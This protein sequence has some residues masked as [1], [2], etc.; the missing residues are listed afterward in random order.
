MTI[1]DT[2]SIHWWQK[3]I[4]TILGIALS[5][6]ILWLTAKLH[7]WIERDPGRTASQLYPHFGLLKVSEP[8]ERSGVGKLIDRVANRVLPGS[9]TNGILDTNGRLRSGHQLAATAVAVLLAIYLLSGVAFSPTS[10]LHPPAAIF[11]LL[12]LLCLLTW[13]FSGLA[14]FFDVLRVPV[15]TFS[16]ALSLVFGSIGTD[17]TFKGNDL[18]DTPASPKRS[19][20]PGNQLGE[21]TLTRRSS[22]LHGRW[23]DT[24]FRVD[25]GSTS[26]DH[27]R[28]PTKRRE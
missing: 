16:L 2:P 3:I 5:V 18:A 20:A 22:W 4:G 9:L 25:C 19:F 28:L 13:A 27:R 23:W 1:S 15:L 8:D 11:F 24:C 7:V 17:H 14:F 10:V 12:F 21:R 6:L 26:Q